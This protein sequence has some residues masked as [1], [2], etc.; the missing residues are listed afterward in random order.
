MHAAGCLAVD[1]CDNLY[2][3][4]YNTQTLYR[5]DTGGN[6]TDYVNFPGG[7]YSHGAEFG[8][9][10]GGFRVDALYVA[11]PYNGDS[12]LEIVVDVP[13]RA[14]DGTGWTPPP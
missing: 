3:C 6:V 8:S 12:V 5:V 1:Y 9:G 7:Q 11:Q 10:I 14:W 2:V 13:G 4:D